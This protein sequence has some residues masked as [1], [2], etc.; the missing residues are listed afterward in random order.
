MGLNARC[1]ASALAAA[2]AVAIGASAAQAV[3]TVTT[4]SQTN[5]TNTLPHTFTPS[6]T[7]LIN[8]LAPSASAGTFTQEGAGGTPVLTN[9]SFPSPITRSPDPTNNFQFSAFAT[10][11]N[12]G[13]TS[14]TYTLAAPGNVHSIDVYGGWQDGGRDQ[15]IYDVF[16]S[17]AG[18]PG[19][20]LSLASVNFNPADPGGNPQVTRVTIGDDAGNLATNVA[21]LRFDFGA[22]ENGYSGY[23]EIDVHAVP[24]PASLGLLGLGALGP[25]A[26]R[27]R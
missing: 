23:A 8:G 18:D 17:T 15:Q 25:L 7:D 6:A 26:R 2:A 11:G 21:A 16:Y 27:R 9:G 1:G 3:V 19:T 20:F 4:A 13:G 14:V 22:T 24:E 10:G 5:G 12:A